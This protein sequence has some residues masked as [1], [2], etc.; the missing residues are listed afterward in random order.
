VLAALDQIARADHV[1][2]ATVAESFDTADE[3]LRMLGRVRRG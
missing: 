1:D 3:V 2:E